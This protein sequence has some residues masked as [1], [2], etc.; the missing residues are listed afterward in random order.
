MSFYMMYV[1]M[2]FNMNYGNSNWLY[3][4]SWNNYLW[5]NLNR[6]LYENN[7]YHYGS[8]HAIIF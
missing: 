8:P 3:E 7:S 2:G 6:N 5:N 4:P 1:A